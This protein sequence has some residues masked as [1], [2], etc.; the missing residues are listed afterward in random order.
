MEK[1]YI[2]NFRGFKKQFFD[3][4]R[5]N[6]I[7]GENSGGKSSFLKFLLS[8]TQTLDDPYQSNLKLKGNLVDL[9]NFNEVIYK[10][11][12]G[13]RI[14]FGFS[15]SNKYFDFFFKFLTKSGLNDDLEEEASNY[16]VNL[17]NI[18]KDHETKITI[19]ISEDLNHHSSINT[20]IEN[21]S[22]G[23][24]TFK[25]K[26]IENI[27][28]AKHQKTNV[29]FDFNG[30]KG[31]IKN[32]TSE[33]S[34]FF[35]LFDD[36]EEKIK[37]QFEIEKFNEIYYQLVYL[38]VF[39]NYCS[40]EI[41]TIRFT[42][43]IAREPKRVYFLGDKN[44]DYQKFNIE[45]VVNVLGNIS[46]NVRQERLNDL[47]ILIK[48]LGIAEEIRLVVID[49]S[50]LKLE[51]KKNDLWINITDGGY[52]VSLNI[53]ILFQALLSEL[54]TNRK[55]TLLIEQPEIHLHP[56]LQS[57]F[58]STLLSIGKKNRYFIETHSEHI[59]RKLQVL[60]KKQ[61]YGLKA[62]DVTIHYFRNENDRFH[63]TEHKIDKFGKLSPSFP[64]GFYDS[65]YNLVKELL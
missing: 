53:P 62:E 24:I 5:V 23:K 57:E 48:K 15:S 10:R 25:S 33:K 44:N 49:E 41:E 55:E 65:T 45:K 13:K 14:E 20:V 38:V 30:L 51:V 40:E 59:I 36:F 63:I 27:G 60:I 58:I 9:G 32:L 31:T 17:L 61:E 47:N 18:V 7:I 35:T 28:Y 37:E 16:L 29:V 1:I 3:F 26:K 52:G 6:I 12:K 43:P 4:S 56:K 50:V 2:D 22:I 11:E 21:K 46:E 8:L 34:G 39:Q 42:N 54:Y 19:N 64:S